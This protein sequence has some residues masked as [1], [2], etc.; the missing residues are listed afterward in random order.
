MYSNDGT[1]WKNPRVLSVLLMVFCTGVLAGALTYRFVRPL[2][3]KAAIPANNKAAFLAKLEKELDLR[4][5]QSKQMSIIL[6]DYKRYYQ[7][8]NE[9]LEDVRATGKSKILNVLDEGQ[10]EKFQRMVPDLPKQ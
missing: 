6:D 4:P 10:R 1:S 3:T 5:E 2:L 9:Q 8:L 7:T